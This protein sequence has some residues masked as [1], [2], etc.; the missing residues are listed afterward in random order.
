MSAYTE[1]VRI[2]DFMN[3]NANLI[4]DL[5]SWVV[6]KVLP[7]EGFRQVKPVQTAVTR[8]KVFHLYSRINNVKTF[9]EKFLVLP[10][11]L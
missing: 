10:R 4:V 1:R 6:K 11:F 9:R 2:G 7:R 5:K 8:N 3:F